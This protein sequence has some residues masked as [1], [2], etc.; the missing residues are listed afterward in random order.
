MHSSPG[1]P[2]GTSRPSASMTCSSVLAI[3][4]PIEIRSSSTRATEDQMV[5]SVGPYMFHSVTPVASRRRA[6]SVGSASPPARAV[7]PGP[8]RQPVSSSMRQAEGVACIIVAPEVTRAVARRAP[9]VTVSRSARTTRAPSTSGS[10][11]SSI[12]MS[13]AKVVTAKR[14]SSL[15]MPGRSF[16]ALRKLPSAPCG[17]WT[18]LGRPVEPEV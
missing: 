7:K 2:G 4:S 10:S 14:L 15:L 17:T 9:S 16:I 12:E 11:S 3:G 1:T 8:P 6:R 13:N 5:V 18:P